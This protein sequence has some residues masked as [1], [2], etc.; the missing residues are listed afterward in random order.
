MQENGDDWK[1]IML[2]GGVKEWSPASQQAKATLAKGGATNTTS[3]ATHMI[4]FSNTERL[5]SSQ[6]PMI[7][8]ANERHKN[9]R[10]H[11]VWSIP[12]PSFLPSKPSS[13]RTCHQFSLLDQPPEPPTCPDTHVGMGPHTPHHIP[14]FWVGTYLSS[15]SQQ[16]YLE[17]AALRTLPSFIM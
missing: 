12:A 13:L 14:S 17:E 7:F 5:N 11:H 4:V 8:H 9:P 16:Q 10:I 1:V 2:R 15:S 3:Q 6:M